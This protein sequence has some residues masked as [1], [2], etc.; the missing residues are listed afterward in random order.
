MAQVIQAE[1][2]KSRPLQ[3]RSK[4]LSHVRRSNGVLATLGN[5]HDGSPPP[6]RRASRRNSKGRARGAPRARHSDRHRAPCRSWCPAE[7]R[8]ILGTSTSAIGGCPFTM[9]EG[10]IVPLTGSG[11]SYPSGSAIASTVR[12]Y[13]PSIT[14]DPPKPPAPPTPTSSWRK[15]LADW[16]G[17]PAAA[18]AVKEAAEWIRDM[19]FRRRRPMEA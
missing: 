8:S 3:R 10:R 14:Q 1:L 5:N 16:V 13:P 12:W 11:V 4:H 2:R 6:L 17:R 18:W 7:C 15:T 19:L 9:D